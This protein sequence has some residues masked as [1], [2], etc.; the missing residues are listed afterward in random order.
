MVVRYCECL[1]LDKSQLHAFVAENASVFSLGV[2]GGESDKAGFVQSALEALKGSGDAEH[3]VLVLDALRIC[4]REKGEGIECATSCS[5]LLTFLRFLER[6]VQSS[7]WD[8]SE[9]ALRC[10][11]NCTYKDLAAAA[12][13]VAPP[14]DGVNV[15]IRLCLPVEENPL[16]CESESESDLPTRHLALRL[17]FMLGTQQ[18]T[19]AETSQLLLAQPSFS[20]S[21]SPLAAIVFQL[22]AVAGL[23]L[24]LG[25]GLGMAEEGGGR[26]G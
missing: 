21:S 19:A 11:T 12:R 18:S 1:Q 17:L 25:L 23:G 20:L 3:A 24:G 9:A 14:V 13:F 5:S 8:L 6:G 26:R 15:I 4:F 16:V 7:R 22:S 10:L 2:L